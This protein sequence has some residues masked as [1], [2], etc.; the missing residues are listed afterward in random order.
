MTTLLP[1]QAAGLIAGTSLRG[2]LYGYNYSD[3]VSVLGTP[4]YNEASGDDKVQK[5]WVVK[6]K[7]FVY[8]LYDWKTYDN[9]YTVND[10]T[11]WNIGGQTYSRWTEFLEDLELRLKTK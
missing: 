8:T 2:Y 4:T 1:T 7:G 9:D 10:N 6:H 11:V 3:L 5:E